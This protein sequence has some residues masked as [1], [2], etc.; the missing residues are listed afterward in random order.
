MPKADLGVLG[1][2]AVADKEVIVIDST[3]VKGRV[4][5]LAG[6]SI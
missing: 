4:R 3:Y 5:S 1:E 6:G 2:K